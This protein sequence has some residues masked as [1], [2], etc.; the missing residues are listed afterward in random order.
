MDQTLKDAGMT[1]RKMYLMLAYAVVLL[2]L[3]FVFIFVGVT[4]FT[5]TGTVGAVIN[6]ILVG[7]VLDRS[8]EEGNPPFAYHS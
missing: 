8:T 6:S 7:V 3:M 2:L 5:G 4:A 1:K